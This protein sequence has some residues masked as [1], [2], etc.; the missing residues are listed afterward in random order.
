MRNFLLVTNSGK[1]N[2]AENSDKIIRTLEKNGCR[3]TAN[4]F[5]KD[6]GEGKYVYVNAGGIPEETEAVLVLGGDGT[7]I[8]AARDI[9]D[10]GLPVFGINY[11]TLGYLTE[12]DVDG[13]EEALLKIISG[14][15]QIEEHIALECTVT[16][17]SRVIVKERIINDIALNRYLSTGI[18]SFSI[19]INDFYLN[20]YDADGVLIAT[21]LGSTGYNLSAGGPLVLPTADIVL[22]TPICAHTLN[23]RSIVF[24]ADVK[25]DII[26]EHRDPPRMSCLICDGEKTADLC[27]GEKISVKKS[28][29]GIKI[30][31]TN[32]IGFVEN[33]GRKMR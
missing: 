6:I 5:T 32:K 9:M 4:Q 24:P 29:S 33:L 15:Y 30:I 12:V 1:K 17:G 16:S 10:L 11:G 18:A 14:D 31:K 7:F 27:G 13:F 19:H 8:H 25:I 20:S 28:S 22:V 3:C 21:P 26:T 2:S 23:S